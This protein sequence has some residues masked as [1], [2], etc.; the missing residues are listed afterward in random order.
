M[1]LPYQAIE[2]GCRRILS[3]L[4]ERA[5][6][7]GIECLSLPCGAS[8]LDAGVNTIGSYQAGA[9][10]TELCQ[11]GLA[12]ASVDVRAM[13]PVLLPHITVESFYPRTANLLLQS[14]ME[15]NGEMISGPIKMFLNKEEIGETPDPSLCP[16]AFAA[17][18][19]SD[20]LPDNDWARSL[21][22]AAGCAP[23]D[24]VLVCVPQGSAAGS[25]QIAGRMNENILFT[26]ERSL[27][28]HSSIVR[29]I[30]GHSP[31][32]PYGPA[33][34]GKR[35]LLP[36]DYLHY[37]SGAYLTVEAPQEVDV[38]K[39]ANDLTFRSLSIYGKL[40][41]ELLE[42]ADWDFFKIPDVMH[43]NKLAE[44]TISDVKS[45][46]FANAGQTDIDKLTAQL[47]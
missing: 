18:L 40:F 39:L 42:E 17:V 46:Q 13:G 47:I 4:T 9:R 12:Q 41:C 11:G 29:H 33:P 20:R 44:V 23:E 26:M 22:E 5:Q 25:T 2:S 43:I 1:S 45:G 16:S 31:I 6:A 24:L 38:E 36:D 3:D 10:V 19:Q 27:G 15:F 35:L 8:V 34:E 7:Y 32:G 21:A 37:A 14:A 30:V 28:V